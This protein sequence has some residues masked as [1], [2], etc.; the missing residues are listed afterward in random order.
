[1]AARPRGCTPADLQWGIPETLGVPS[2]SRGHGLLPCVPVIPLAVRRRQGVGKNG[3]PTVAA[4][5]PL[6]KTDDGYDGE[7]VLATRAIW[8]WPLRRRSRRGFYLPAWSH[9]TRTRGLHP[10]RARHARRSVEDGVDEVGPLVRGIGTRARMCDQVANS[11]W[12]KG[13]HRWATGVR[14]RRE[15][16]RLTRGPVLSAHAGWSWAVRAW[17]ENQQWAEC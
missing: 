3:N 8:N 2:S 9:A 15:K 11:H 7:R 13:V 5:W 1:M 12:Q 4:V 6:D 17:G 10:R 16:E 14:K